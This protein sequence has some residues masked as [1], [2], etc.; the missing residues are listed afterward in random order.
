MDN[1]RSY[2]GGRSWDVENKALT[3]A[4]VLGQRLGPGRTESFA[5]LT[6]DLA[7]TITGIAAVHA[8]AA[9]VEMYEVDINQLLA[10]PTRLT[11]IIEREDTK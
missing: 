11:R 6:F 3:V 8:G 10:C 9:P 5:G 1:P 4:A 2:L 7:S